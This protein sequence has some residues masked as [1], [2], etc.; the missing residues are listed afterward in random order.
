MSLAAVRE[1]LARAKDEHGVRVEPR[2]ELLSL[3]APRKPPEA[4]L[5]E[6][7]AHKTELLRLLAER[8]YERRF[9][10]PHARLFALL[11]R[12]VDTPLGPG[13]LVQVAAE[14][15]AVVVRGRAVFVLTGDVGPTQR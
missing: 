12:I 1:L 6:L 14:R 15:C 5:A 9:R 10:Q 2:G 13:P 3:S 11:G 8:D 7:R 4:L